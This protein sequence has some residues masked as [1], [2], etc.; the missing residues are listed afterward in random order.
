MHTPYMPSHPFPHI[1]SVESLQIMN[2]ANVFV[3]IR[4][5]PKP[6][7]PLN[8]IMGDRVY[9]YVIDEMVIAKRNGGNPL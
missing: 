6:R 4:Q 2:T 7:T 9:P 1:P 5:L 8:I 3:L